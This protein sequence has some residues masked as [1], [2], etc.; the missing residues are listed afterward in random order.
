MRSLID[1]VA[2]EGGQLS[3]QVAFRV[4]L[5]EAVVI[6]PDLKEMNVRRG[7]LWRGRRRIRE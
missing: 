3:F 7:P 2:E 4:I 1:I 5:L 6:V